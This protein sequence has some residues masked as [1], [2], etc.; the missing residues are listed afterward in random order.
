MSKRKP[1]VLEDGQVEQLPFGDHTDL[2]GILNVGPGFP[3]PANNT[4]TFQRTNS[5]FTN[6]GGTQNVDQINGGNDGDILILR[7]LSSASNVKVRRNQGNILVKQNRFFN[8]GTDL[9]VLLKVSIFWVELN[10]RN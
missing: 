5:V 8:S 1:L 2:G 10:W 7:K 4:I 9:L 6:N 3:V